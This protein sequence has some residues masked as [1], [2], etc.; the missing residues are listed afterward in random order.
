[1]CGC[2]HTRTSVRGPVRGLGFVGRAGKH[3]INTRGPSYR[4]LLKRGKHAISPAHLQIFHHQ[5]LPEAR[6]GRS[7]GTIREKQA[8]GAHAA[9]AADS[10]I[11]HLGLHQDVREELLARLALTRSGTQRAHPAQE[12]GA[13]SATVTQGPGSPVRGTV[14]TQRDGNAPW[15]RRNDGER[16][17]SSRH[18]CRHVRAQESV[19]REVL[20]AKVVLHLSHD[21]A[22]IHP[23]AFTA[24]P[25]SLARPL[26]PFHTRM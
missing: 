5:L 1:M 24:A 11:K 23:R 26:H 9:S 21:G 20:V 14:Q 16:H 22:L 25:W 12:G 10:C 17:G 18:A 13:Q 15:K 2:A 4:G 6:S 3:P 19:R 8:W 7:R